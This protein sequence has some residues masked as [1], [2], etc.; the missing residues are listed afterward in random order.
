MKTK[1]TLLI[2]ASALSLQAQAALKK[3]AFSVFGNQKHFVEVTCVG[4]KGFDNGLTVR[5]YSPNAAALDFN[6]EYKLSDLSGL[7]FSVSSKRAEDTLKVSL[8][9]DEQERVTAGTYGGL[10]VTL[11]RGS[12]NVS[13]DLNDG[14]Q[15]TDN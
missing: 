15:I 5:L 2:L 10:D 13:C 11:K 8:W 6:G 14:A 4:I 3:P 1:L 12:V 7:D 9:A